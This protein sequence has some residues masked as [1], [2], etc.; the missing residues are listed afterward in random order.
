MRQTELLWCGVLE[1]R[2]NWCVQAAA[3]ECNREKWRSPS[4]KLVIV[5]SLI[6]SPS[7]DDRWTGPSEQVFSLWS[8]TVLVTVSLSV[9]FM[10]RPVKKNQRNSF[11]GINVLGCFCLNQNSQRVDNDVLVASGP[12]HHPFLNFRLLLL[13]N[14]FCTFFLNHNYPT[15]HQL[16]SWIHW[17]SN[18]FAC[19]MRK[20]VSGIRFVR[21]DK[22]PCL[23][24]VWLMM[25]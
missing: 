5:R 10:L 3:F 6:G 14:I 24:A 1:M 22:C 16:N 12:F 2:L 13:T 25:H 8:L 21:L 15:K 19:E 20:F 17:G 7:C 23:P 4:P 11:V 18:F 9:G